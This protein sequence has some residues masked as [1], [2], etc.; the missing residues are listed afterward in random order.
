[1]S[2][3]RDE[4]K[5]LQDL[6]DEDLDEAVD[7]ESD[8][9]FVVS[10]GPSLVTVNSEDDKRREPKPFPKCSAAEM[11]TALRQ[12]PDLTSTATVTNP[13]NEQQQHIVG[14][15]DDTKHQSKTKS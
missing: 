13:L 15:E 3:Y 9:D 11:L 6:F 12:S 7:Y 5:T 14:R 10:N 4:S 2:S 8:T 1:M